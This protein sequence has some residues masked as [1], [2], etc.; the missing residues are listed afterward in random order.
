[1]GWASASSQALT[2]GNVGLKLYPATAAEAAALAAIYDYGFGNERAGWLNVL[3]FIV[4]D[5]ASD[6]RDALLDAIAVLGNAGGGV[7]F[8]PPLA[9]KIL[10]DGVLTIDYDG[11]WIIGS[12]GPTAQSIIEFVHAGGHAVHISKRS[13]GLIDLRLQADATRRAG[14]DGD[15]VHIESAD[16]AQGV[17]AASSLSRTKLWRLSI[18]SQPGWG[19]YNAGGA[20]YFE[21]D[22][23][24]IADCIKGFAM[25]DGTRAGRTNKDLAPFNFQIRNTRVCQVNGTGWA[26]GH[27]SETNACRNGILDSCA[28]LGCNWDSAE[29]ESLYQMELKC[30]GLL[31]RNPNVEDQQYADA[32]T[33]TTGIAKTV[34]S[35]PSSGLR[36]LSG[37]FRSVGGQFS[38]LLDSMT[39]AGSVDDVEIDMGAIFAGT[40]PTLQTDGV[41]VP[42]TVTNFRFKGSTG[43]TP[44]ATNLLKNQSRDARI[45]INAKNYRGTLV[46]TGDFEINSQGAAATIAGGT[47]TIG[48][49]KILLAGE[50]GVADS[51][52]VLRIAS[53]I[54]G[55]NGLKTTLF[56]ANAYDLTLVHGTTMFFRSGSNFVLQQNQA[57]ALE[58]D[59]TIG[60]WVETS[61][62]LAGPVVTITRTGT[63]VESST[64]AANAS[65]TAANNNAVLAKLLDILRDKGVLDLA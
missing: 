42:S 12:G 23:N 9:N 6:N 54:N 57:I 36:V 26:I 60:G 41:I 4:D 55:Y 46:S 33:V 51:L 59:E 29:R 32:T 21:S 64:L 19:I 62:N 5:G 1:M 58:Y 25:D 49:D 38:S 47:V 13:C 56:N 45:R 39:I 11:V 43:R 53:G 2:R 27:G 31:M 65:A 50:G 8:V 61:D 7:L 37:G 22:T 63:V 17:G 15:G 18:R 24:T 3:R 40:Y 16:L 20:E 30:N 34:L 44:G 10:C 48:A 52:T 35:T 14:A 28:S